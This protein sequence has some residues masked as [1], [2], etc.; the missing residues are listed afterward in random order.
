MQMKSGNWRAPQQARR[1]TELPVEN[2][3]GALAAADCTAPSSSSA[4]RTRTLAPRPFRCPPSPPRPLLRCSQPAR[5]SPAP[6]SPSRPSGEAV[7]S[8]MS[9]ATGPSGPGSPGSAARSA[10]GR[11]V[12]WPRTCLR[13][14]QCVDRCRHRQPSHHVFI[15]I[16]SSEVA[17]RSWGITYW[18]DSDLG[19]CCDRRREGRSR[20]LRQISERPRATHVARRD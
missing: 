8:V 6:P 13:S 16:D 15:F 3:R 10:A 2:A 5:R 9:S 11:R 17:R 14:R 20:R 7:C 1:R 12:T 4:A 18:L 19:H